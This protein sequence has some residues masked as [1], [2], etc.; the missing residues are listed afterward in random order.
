MSE[1]REIPSKV[2]EACATLRT[3]GDLYTLLRW[4]LEQYECGKEN[5]FEDERAELY[6]RGQRQT[7]LFLCELIGVEVTLVGGRAQVT[8]K[9]N[10]REND[11]ES[12]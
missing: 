5:F 4:A 6:A 9:S 10:E 12:P 11:S 1:I 7:I 2:K 8:E 3:K